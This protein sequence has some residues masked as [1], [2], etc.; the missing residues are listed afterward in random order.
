MSDRTQ[1]ETETSLYQNAADRST[2]ELCTEDAVWQRRLE[3]MGIA[4]T[5][6][7]GDARWYTLR[8]DQVLIRKGK[9]ATSEAQREVARARMAAMQAARTIG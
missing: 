5:R 9:R 2:W 1:E 6:T 4:P 8:A 7:R 3:A